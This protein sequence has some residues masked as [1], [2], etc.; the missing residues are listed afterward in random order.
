MAR[1][2]PLS[3]AV[4]DGGVGRKPTVLVADSDA[5]LHPI[6]A[7]VLETAGYETRFAADGIE[8]VAMVARGAP[9]LLVLDLHLDRLDGLLALEVVRAITRQLPIVLTSSLTGPSIGLAA[10][11]LGA[12]AVLRKPFR[13]ADLLEAV[14]R[15][16][17]C[18]HP[19]VPTVAEIPSP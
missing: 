18:A 17:A 3:P 14:G 2:V 19:S 13:N 15:G 8:L 4:I 16:L 11:R 9:D 1:F 6:L 7:D 10:R 12:L 5:D